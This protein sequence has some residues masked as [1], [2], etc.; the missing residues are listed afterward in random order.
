MS[1]IFSYQKFFLSCF[2]YYGM[3]I[4]RHSI[5]ANWN[6]KSNILDLNIEIIVLYIYLAMYLMF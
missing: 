6:A 3:D 5:I 1:R 2:I 4:K